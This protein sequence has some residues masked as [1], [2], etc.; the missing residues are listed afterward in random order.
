MSDSDT[1]SIA[2]GKRLRRMDIDEKFQGML[3]VDKEFC[4]CQRAAHVMVNSRRVKGC[5]YTYSGHVI[6]FMQNTGKIVNRLL[7]VSAELQVMVLKPS[8]NGVK[9]SK[10][11]RRFEEDFRVQR[12]HVEIW[13]KYLIEHSDYNL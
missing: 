5:Q 12:D 13:L 10:T 9:N 6:N 11:H 2:R 8:P 4:G 1:P 7:S 3:G